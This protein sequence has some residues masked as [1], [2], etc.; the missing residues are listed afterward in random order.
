MAFSQVKT[1]RVK[2]RGDV[3]SALHGR[4]QPSASVGT[5]L[6]GKWRLAWDT[7][8]VSWWLTHWRTAK[9]SNMQRRQELNDVSVLVWGAKAWSRSTPWHLCDTKLHMIMDESQ[10]I[11]L[12]SISTLSLAKC[13]CCPQSQIQLRRRRS[14]SCINLCFK[15][16]HIHTWQL[17]LG[18]NGYFPW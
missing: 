4:W 2:R 5:I 15:I 18:Q 10:F 17:V 8:C 16:F 12:P 6:E 9:R 1:S 11:P 14:K 13:K 3:H 7:L